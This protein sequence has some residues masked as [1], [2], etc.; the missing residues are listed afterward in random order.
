MPTLGDFHIAD[1][2][3]L[4]DEKSGLILYDYIKYKYRYPTK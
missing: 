2:D 1:G 3:S 4:G